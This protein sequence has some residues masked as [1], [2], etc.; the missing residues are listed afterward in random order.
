MEVQA[1]AA[2]VEMERVLRP[3]LAFP[4]R[5]I[6]EERLYQVEQVRPLAVLRAMNSLLLQMQV[7]E[8]V[9]VLLVLV[10]NQITLLLE[11]V[12]TVRQHF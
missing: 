3:I 5:V 7:V 8:V 12:E 9:V 2:V 10:F 1:V 11:L 6:Q 4:I